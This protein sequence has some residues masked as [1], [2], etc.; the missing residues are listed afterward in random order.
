MAAHDC[1]TLRRS[2]ERYP[3]FRPMQEIH[4]SSVL[5]LTFITGKHSFLT[6]QTLEIRAIGVQLHRLRP[7]RHFRP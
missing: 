4:S 6:Y 7:A 2:V 1:F 3:R 5:N